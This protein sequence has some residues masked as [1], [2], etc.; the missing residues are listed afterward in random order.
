MSIVGFSPESQNDVFKVVSAI[1]NLG[2]IHFKN[3]GDD[4][5]EIENRNQL[6]ITAK[7]LQV[8][9]NDLEEALICHQVK[10]GKDVIKKNI[11]VSKVKFLIYLLFFQR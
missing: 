10:T 2:N 7:L 11:S 6:E 1:L 9:V 5:A 4:V 3:A 8:P